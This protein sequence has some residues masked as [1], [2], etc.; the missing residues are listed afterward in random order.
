MD[1]VRVLTVRQPWAG[2]IIWHGKDRENRPKPMRYR[3][4]V[5]VHA[6]LHVPDSGD[7]LA[8]RD[9]AAR[10]PEWNDAR[11]ARGVILGLVRVTGCHFASDCR[12]AVRRDGEPRYCTWWATG[13][14]WHIEV[15]D[16]VA[17][18]EP[19]PCKGKLGLW[20]LPADV[21]K[22]VRD[23]LEEASRGRS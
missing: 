21:E 2:A 9:M 14:Q 13:E 11:R 18:A 7:F 22:A 10:S 20:R 3:G 23:Q 19:V 17:L 16:P 4:L 5:A 15:T 1:E 6:G 8:V 12:K